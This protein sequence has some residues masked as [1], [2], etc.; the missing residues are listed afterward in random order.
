[1]GIEP[2]APNPNWLNCQT[3]PNLNIR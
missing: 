2:N 1:M 3:E